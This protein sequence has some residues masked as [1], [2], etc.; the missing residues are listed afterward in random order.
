MSEAIGEEESGERC[1]RCGEIGQDRRTLWMACFYAMEE[2]GAVPFTQCALE[3]VYRP[4]SGKRPVSERISVMVPEWGPLDN[5]NP[6][7]RPFYTLRVCKDCRADW[8][9]AI[10]R[11]FREVRPVESCGSGIFVRRNGAT[12]EVSREE[13]DR[14]NPGREPVR[15]SP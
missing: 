4:L 5:D 15:V 7:L 10:G 8:M 14:M 13:W 11:W 1:Q 3:G 2:I 9:D 12:V 6:E